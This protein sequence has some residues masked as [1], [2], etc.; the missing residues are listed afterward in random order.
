MVVVVVVI[1][2]VVVVVVVLVTPDIIDA[3]SHMPPPASTTDVEADVE[4]DAAPAEPSVAKGEAPCDC[5]GDGVP[6]S[7]TVTVDV[8][9]VF[10]ALGAVMLSV[11]AEEATAPRVFSSNTRFDLPAR[12]L[13][14]KRPP[15]LPSL[16]TPIAWATPRPRRPSTEMSERLRTMPPVLTVLVV[17]PILW[18]GSTLGAVRRAGEST[19]RRPMFA[20]DRKSL[21]QWPTGE[22]E[23]D[24]TCS[25]KAT[26]DMVEDEATGR[27]RWWQWLGCR[28]AGSV[29][30]TAILLFK[31]ARAWRVR[32]LAH[33]S[34]SSSQSL[35][36]PP[37]SS[38]SKSNGSMS[39][40]E[41][42]VEMCEGFLRSPVLPGLGIQGSRGGPPHKIQ[43]IA[44]LTS[45]KPDRFARWETSIRHSG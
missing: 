13:P 44:S 41:S 16:K 7:C 29:T 43:L 17:T 42:S 33:D 8:V 19:E 10:A 32:S 9:I 1:V 30:V 45:P 3:V 40:L 31:P 36:L 35:S 2:V 26:L 6:D 37:S 11:G 23:A 34:H 25:D 27:M 22:V 15:P 20:P 38:A 18:N 5:V 4:A 21:R 28:D 14:A 12:C 24:V 39:V